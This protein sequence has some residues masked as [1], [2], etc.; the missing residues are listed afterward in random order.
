MLAGGEGEDAEAT[1]MNSH[2]EPDREELE[3]ILKCHSNTQAKC[4]ELVH[5][6]IPGLMYGPLLD[7]LMAWARRET[8]RVWC[9]HWKWNQDMR[10]W[11]G[12]AHEEGPLLKWYE[13]RLANDSG[14][15]SLK[16]TVCPIC[17]VKRPT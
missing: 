6:T 9:S 1:A 4:V 2:T 17:G 16:W 15:N 10:D 5:P 7:D 12:T 3:K 14:W 13:N 8:Q 11:E